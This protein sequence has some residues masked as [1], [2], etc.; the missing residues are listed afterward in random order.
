MLGAY[1]H[2]RASGGG[3]CNSGH[4]TH[5]R[6]A[7]EKEVIHP[8]H[9][10]RHQEGGTRHALEEPPREPPPTQQRYETRSAAQA[11]ADQ[12]DTTRRRVCNALQLCRP[13]PVA[14]GP[15]QL[16]RN[17]V[18]VTSQHKLV[19]VAKIEKPF[20]ERHVL[21][22]VRARPDLTQKRV[23]DF[24]EIRQVRHSSNEQRVAE[25]GRH[26]RLECMP[27][28]LDKRGR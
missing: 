10:R 17:G 20:Q 6:D 2:A 28:G 21:L 8:R 24:N 13:P 16:S 5:S 12:G 11:Q 9:P 14:L 19:V 18:T 22:A 4:P 23:V 27:H 25:V 15:R 1:R 26:V 3:N 7:K